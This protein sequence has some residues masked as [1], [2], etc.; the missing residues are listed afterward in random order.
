ME[1]LENEVVLP[2]TNETETNNEIDTQSIP[3]G[4]ETSQTQTPEPEQFLDL[5]YNKDI[6]W[7]DKNTARELAQMGKNYPKIKEKLDQYENNKLLKY[8]QAK[9]FDPDDLVSQWEKEE[10]ERSIQ[11]YAIRN[12][13][14]YG[15]AQRMHDVENRLA[16][17]EESQKAELEARQQEE[18]SVK[19]FT[20]LTNWHKD[21]FGKELVVDEIP[22]EVIEIKDNTG[23]TFKDAYIEYEFNKLMTQ[24]KEQQKQQENAQ[25]STGSV[26][27]NGTTTPTTFTKESVEKMTSQEMAK[28]WDNPLFRKVAG[29]MK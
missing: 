5:K 1:E 13:V 22:K 7:V 3:D 8:I 10:Q 28:H 9:G 29:L 25:T 17:F 11:D 12:N 23:K 19:E 18:M 14:D 15:T 6:E 24:Q 26:T 4:E 27:N 2:D 21:T 16:K 20:D